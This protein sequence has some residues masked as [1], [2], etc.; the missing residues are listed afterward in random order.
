MLN[1]NQDTELERIAEKNVLEEAQRFGEYGIVGLHRFIHTYGILAKCN[2]TGYS[3]RWCYKTRLEAAGA[4]KDWVNGVTEQP[5][6]YTR[7]LGVE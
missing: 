6:G 7:K 1:T 3:M 5:E 2:D 4:L